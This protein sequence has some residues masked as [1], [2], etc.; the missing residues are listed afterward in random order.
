MPTTS[1]IARIAREAGEAGKRGDR[2][3]SHNG[4]IFDLRKGGY[5]ARFVRQVHESVLGLPPMSWAF[6]APTARVMEN[7]LRA[8]GRQVTGAPRP[9]DI[10][11]VNGGSGSY[12]HI[13]IYLGGGLFAENTSSARGPGTTISNVSLVQSRVTGYYRA[14]PLPTGPGIYK[15]IRHSDGALLGQFSL[16]AGNYKVV[17]DGDHM[18][19]DGKLYVQADPVAPG[20]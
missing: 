20:G 16:P 14:L 6:A 18:A 3:Y 10:L 12:G 7:L 17:P 1:D 8:A 2:T 4:V 19:D 11:A 9:G 5:C 13:G 15:V